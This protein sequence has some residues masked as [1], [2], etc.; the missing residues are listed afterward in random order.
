MT[1]THPSRSDLASLRVIFAFW[2]AFWAIWAS[3]TTQKGPSEAPQTQ[4]ERSRAEL[5]AEY[6]HLGRQALSLGCMD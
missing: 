3:Q 6:R 5:R 2:G 1:H 4:P